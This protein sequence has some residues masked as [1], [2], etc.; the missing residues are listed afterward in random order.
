MKKS[1]VQPI[2]KSNFQNIESTSVNY[3]DIIDE[4][5]TQINKYNSNHNIN[6]DDFKNISDPD[7]QKTIIMNLLKTEYNF[8]TDYVL[9]TDKELKK[10]KNT[11]GVKKEQ[12]TNLE[13]ILKSSADINS[14]NKRGFEINKYEYDKKSDHLKF[15]RMCIYILGALLLLPILRYFGVLT[16]GIAFLIFFFVICMTFMY[17]FYKIKLD[18]KNRDTKIYDRFRFKTPTQKDLYT[19][20]L[21]AN[22]S[23]SCLAQPA[24]QPENIVDESV[25]D[26]YKTD[27]PNNKCDVPM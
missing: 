4:I 19:K 13:R 9:F 27:L 12:L 8:A 16:K 20:L 23:G 7:T 2:S 26:K 14:T 25:F 18:D 10:K 24:N 17:G 5:Q 22:E 11:H 6:F 3:N 21:D 1:N 15:F